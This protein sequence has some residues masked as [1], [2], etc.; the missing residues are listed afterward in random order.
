MKI[1]IVDENR[2]M[3]RITRHLLR[4]LGYEDVVEVNDGEAALAAMRAQRIDLVIADANT[5]PMSGLELLQW[6][7]YDAGLKDTPF[8]MLVMDDRS[9]KIISI[10]EAGVSAY[11]VRPFTAD[12]LKQTLD[13]FV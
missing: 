3:R 11:L 6:V 1:L 12:T 5:E 10:R 13:Y 4:Q 2:T 7:R 9:E 8:V